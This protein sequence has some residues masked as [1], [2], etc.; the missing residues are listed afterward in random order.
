MNRNEQAKAAIV[1]IALVGVFSLFSVR[2]IY[3]Q[4]IEHDAYVALAAEKHVH[5]QVI[6]ARRG[7]I[8]GCHGE[9]L[10]ENRRVYDVVA[11]GSRIRNP[12][13]LAQAIAGQLEMDPRELEAKL[14]LAVTKTIANKKE[15]SKVLKKGVSEDA[16]ENIKKITRDGQ[17]DLDGIFFDL[18]FD[19]VYPNGSLLA[20]VV[21]FLDAGHEAR[22]GIEK[23]MDDFLRGTNG[24]RY[25]EEDRKGHELVQYRGLETPAKDGCDVKLTIDLVLQNIVESELDA[26]CDQYKPKMATAILMRPQTGEILAMASR[27]TFDCND[28]KSSTADQQKNRP[29]VD[30]LE[31]G[32]TFKIVVSSAA[33]EEKLATPD[34]KIYCENGAYSYAGRILHDAHPMGM[35]TLHQ[36]LS[37]SS[38]IGAAKLAIQLGKDK[39]YQYIR[40]YGFGESTG[41]PLPGEIAGLVN[42]P[43]RWSELDITRV[44]MGQSVA[45]TPLQLVTAMSV[46]ANG[47]V[48]MKPMIVSEID[49]ADGRQVVAYSPTQVRRVISSATALKIV[50]ALKDVVSKEG[51]AQ[52]AAVPGFAV[53]GKT[54][55][56]QKI[57]P[58][59]GYLEGRYVV[60]FVGFMPADDPKFTLLVVIDDPETKKGEAFGG[61]VAGPIFAKMAKRVADYLELQPTTPQPGPGLVE[62]PKNFV[63]TPPGRG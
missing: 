25:L 11:A 41:I 10:A 29:I 15:E 44:P 35:L 49:D 40:R 52:G 56:A 57:D 7:V 39:F 16:F 22:L 8:R 42:P 62:T 53:A 20:Q 55:T 32:S 27:P 47:G 30:M 36:V 59:G 14:K 9:P 34:T 24:F 17:H 1:C 13:A 4:V 46:I 33:L 63:S 50:S 21:G 5:K 23:S 54:G 19:R 48:L 58:R 3:L 60:S 26:A 43:Y 45:V 12:A 31:P 2:L 6:Y 18:N 61:T 51:T 37:K 28:P 38:N